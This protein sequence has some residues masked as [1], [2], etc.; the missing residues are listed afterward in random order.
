MRGENGD[1]WFNIPFR[2]SRRLPFSA[3]RTRAQERM[4]MK[5]VCKDLRL[6]K[7]LGHGWPW[8]QPKPKPYKP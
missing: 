6:G 3:T 2:V 5:F 7:R 1:T 8:E 4:V